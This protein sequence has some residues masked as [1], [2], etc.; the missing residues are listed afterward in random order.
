MKVVFLFAIVCATLM[1]SLQAKDS[2][3]PL[4]KPYAG[5]QVSDSK[6]FEY[7]EGE[8]PLGIIE[9]SSYDQVKVRATAGRFTYNRFSK[10][11]TSSIDIYR[12]YLNA[13]KKQGFQIEFSCAPEECGYYVEDYLETQSALKQLTPLLNRKSAF[14]VANYQSEGNKASVLFAV[15]D[16]LNPVNF[17]QVVIDEYQPSFDKVAV[18]TAAYKKFLEQ[19]KSD[20]KQPTNE[21][22]DVDGAQDHPLI[23]RYKGAALTNY[24]SFGYE[25]IALPIAKVESDKPAQSLTTKGSAKFY[26]YS[27]PRGV[28]L[29]EVE[30]SYENAFKKN[31]FEVIFSCRKESCGRYM[32]SYLESNNIF[33]GFYPTLLGD[34]PVYVVRHSTEFANTLLLVTFADWNSYIDVYQAV[35]QE[36][37]IDNNK[38]LVN[39]DYLQEQIAANGKVALYGIN[40]NYDSDQMTD[41]SIKPLAAIADFLKKNSSLS[42]YVVGHTDADGNEDY[43]QQLSFKRA[44]AVTEKLVKEFGVA[45]SR[46]T[47]KG[48]GNLVPVASN[49]LDDGKRLNRR[50]ELVEKL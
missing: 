5:A 16:A 20:S 23:S 12:N 13:F 8:L 37:A 9:S 3:H 39:A 30:K 7:F 29:I 28:S 46:L 49:K 19:A 45:R 32:E 40:F 50:V 27:T 43:N 44:Q 41:A 31:G 18:D 21:F 35:I 14:I 15:S 25:E 2:Q 42:L 48:V 6:Y 34:I 22:R 17:Y 11:N 36:S 1:P 47:P 4:I 24:S 10:E 38:V 33:K 26:R